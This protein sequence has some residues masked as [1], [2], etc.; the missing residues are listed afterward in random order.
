MERV[1]AIEH[2]VAVPVCVFARHQQLE[3]RLFRGD[4]VFHASY[5]EP[6]S[7][8]RMN[9]NGSEP[10]TRR[11]RNFSLW[12][13]YARVDVARDECVFHDCVS[14][15][16]GKGGVAE[17]LTGCGHDCQRTVLDTTRSDG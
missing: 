2:V 11:L 17:D 14:D 12:I 7:C 1:H 4:V 5:S 6:E 9:E 3:S 8:T 10:L 15:F 13:L 16:R